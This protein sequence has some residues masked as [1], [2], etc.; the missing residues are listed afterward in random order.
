MTS[1][2]RRKSLLNKLFSSC[3]TLKFPLKF[4][5]SCWYLNVCYLKLFLCFMTCVIYSVFADFPLTCIRHGHW[6]ILS[7]KNSLVNIERLKVCTFFFLN[8][9][10][11]EIVVFYIH[12]YIDVL[13]FSRQIT[14]HTYNM[15]LTNEV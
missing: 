9:V 3:Q 4:G 2:F 13:I 12:L 11:A 5:C 7:N 1:I 14:S 10:A 15:L 6:C 8:V